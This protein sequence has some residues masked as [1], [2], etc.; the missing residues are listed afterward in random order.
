MFKRKK[1]RKPLN[2]YF[3][4]PTS[5]KINNIIKQVLPVIPQPKNSGTSDS[6]GLAKAYS[7]PNAIY[8]GGNKAYVAG[9][10]SAGEAFRGW[11]KKSQ[12]VI[13]QILN[14]MDN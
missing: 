7:S 8:I 2:D 14:D 5:M 1:H 13:Q 4:P 11:G 3:R 6:E 9:A 10:R 12:H